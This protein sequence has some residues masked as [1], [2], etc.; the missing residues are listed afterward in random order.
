MLLIVNKI[1]NNIINF[2]LGQNYQQKNNAESLIFL[3]LNSVNDQ[4]TLYVLDQM[5]KLIMSKEDFYTKE[6]NQNYQLF[7]LFIVPLISR[8]KSLS[9]NLMGNISNIAFISLIVSIWPSNIL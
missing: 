7:K 2:Y 1:R 5:N 6:E 8:V 4:S 3:L 9:M